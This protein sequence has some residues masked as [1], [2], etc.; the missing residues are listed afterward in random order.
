MLIF[1]RGG[2]GGTPPPKNKNKFWTASHLPWKAVR[3]FVPPSAGHSHF[4]IS[5]PMYAILTAFWI[6]SACS[7]E[8]ADDMITDMDE[9]CKKDR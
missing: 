2:G 8:M 4:G 9:P 1:E 5:K 3:P 6:L 7:E